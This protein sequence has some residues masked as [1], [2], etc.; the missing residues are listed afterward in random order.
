[1][2]FESGK[3]LDRGWSSGRKVFSLLKKDSRWKV[4]GGREK[5]LES[6]S[7]I[8][9]IKEDRL[10]RIDRMVLLRLDI[11]DEVFIFILIYL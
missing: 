4:D 3:K 7:L 9:R 11:R 10:C 8:E 6:L 5:R 2:A 1:M